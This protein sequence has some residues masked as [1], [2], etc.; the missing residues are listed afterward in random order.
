M[1]IGVVGLGVIAPYFLRAIEDDEQLTLTA[2]AD[3]NP[4]KLADWTDPARGVATYT[5]HRELLAS[6][7]VDAV[8]LTLP[9]AVHA[10]VAADAL[11][12]GVHVC[13]EKPMTVHLADARKLVALARTSGRTLFTAFHRRY[14]RNVAA[15]RDSVGDPATIER[16]VCRYSERIEEHTGSEAWY[17]DQDLGGGGCIIDNGPNALDAVRTIVGDLELL[18]ATIGDVRRGVEFC[19]ELQLRSVDGVRVTIELDWAL[20]SGEVKDITV[21]GK[22]GSVRS[23]DMLAGFP[24]FKSSLDHEYAAIMADFRHA[25]S[26]GQAYTDAGPEIVALV[27]QAYAVARR[28]EPRLRMQS[29][30]PTVA[31]FVK[32]MFHRR[33][34]RGMTMSPWLSR[35]VRQGEIHELVT[36]TDQPTRPGDR[37][38]AVG[39]LGFAEFAVATVVQRGD[40]VVCNGQRI[41]T[42]AGFD[43]CH[44]PN[45]YN[46][47]I[48]TERI[49]TAEDLSLQVGDS[50]QLL[51]V[52][53]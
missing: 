14:N 21:Y 20:P 40:V 17:L 51:E 41:G 24:G 13:C 44:W 2:V 9:N 1:R 48:D 19:A 22:D 25:V 33:D 12:A 3:R 37:V 4:A 47:L 53:P 38:D 7:L 35:C 43:E 32:L 11:R 27:E 6:G 15:L 29:K 34:E 18:D 36:T 39:F 28:K 5:D 8:V 26:L 16:L 49:V 45:H 31:R 23:A 30:Q 50:L 52:V 42:V 46:I 10:Q